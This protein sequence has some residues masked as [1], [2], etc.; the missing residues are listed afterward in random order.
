M[1]KTTDLLKSLGLSEIEAKLYQGLL[2][3]GSTTIMELASYVGIKR[4]TAHFN[5][6]S[7]IAK[8]LVVQTKHGARRQ[9]VAE[10][11]EK[12]S[13][14][15]E[16]K[17]RA[18]SEMKANLP[19]LISSLTSK[20]KATTN[21]IEDVGI[22]YY[23]GEKGFKEV[24]QR[25]L[26]YADGEIKF[27]SNL[28]EWHKVYTEEYDKTHYIPTRLGKKIRLKLLVPSIEKAKYS[29]VDNE[30]LLREVRHLPNLSSFKTT[31]IIY[32]DEVSIMLSVKP[33]IAI[34]IRDEELSRTFKLLFDQLWGISEINSH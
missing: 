3:M 29:E 28:G 24:C 10:P 20:Y 32:G 17:E 7:L 8:G 9:I 16:A 22:L 2:E 13:S 31:L 6:E 11:P 5:I 23:E 30:K 21:A 1:K 18:I 26:D 14:L 27:I 4:I 15:I 34:V 33:Y 25:S 19:E 12:I